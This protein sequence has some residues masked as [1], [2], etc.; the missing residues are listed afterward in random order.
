MQRTVCLHHAPP[1]LV[2]MC[3]AESSQAMASMLIP[4][5]YIS[6]IRRTTSASDSITTSFPRQYPDP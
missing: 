1:F 6:K 5:P 3:S 2:G 4:L